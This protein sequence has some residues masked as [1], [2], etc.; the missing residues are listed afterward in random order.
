M[1][2]RRTNRCKSLPFGIKYYTKSKFFTRG[3]TA[4]KDASQKRTGL[5]M[6]FL[7]KH[8]ILKLTILYFQ[9]K[10]LRCGVPSYVTNKWHKRNHFVTGKCCY[11]SVKKL[12]NDSKIDRTKWVSSCL[13]IIL[14]S[15]EIFFHKYLNISLNKGHKNFLGNRDLIWIFVH[16]VCLYSKQL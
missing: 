15:S 1:A 12:W 14:Y 7:K 4:F 10:S 3:P 13:T 6:W 5:K 2:K 16:F 11:Q 9:L 8:F